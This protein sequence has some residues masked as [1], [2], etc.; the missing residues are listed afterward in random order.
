MTIEAQVELGTAKGT[1]VL[2]DESRNG[3]KVTWQGRT[4]LLWRRI[5]GEVADQL[6][7]V[8]NPTFTS[9]QVRI[10]GARG[11]RMDILDAWSMGEYLNLVWLSA[12][13]RGLSFT[14]KSD[15]FEIDF[16]VPSVGPSEE[17]TGTPASAPFEQ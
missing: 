9:D 12:R 6:R 2:D 4:P 10:T 3:F 1:V 13:D 7:D 15:A 17:L 14:V 11:N 8:E 5:E 16:T